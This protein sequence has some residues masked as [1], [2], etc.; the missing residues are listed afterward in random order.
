MKVSLGCDHGGYA[1]KEEIKKHLEEKGIEYVD[2]GTYST[3]SVDYPDFARQ[4]A[5]KYSP[6]SVILPCFIVP[7]A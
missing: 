7:Q 5:K 6:V 3:D 4:L 1:L 2:C